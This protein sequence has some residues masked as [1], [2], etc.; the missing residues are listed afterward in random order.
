MNRFFAIVIMSAVLLPSLSYDPA[1]ADALGSPTGG[2]GHS[3][4]LS[5]VVVMPGEE[6]KRWFSAEVIAEAKETEKTGAKLIKIKGCTVCH[7]TDGTPLIGPTF[8]GIFK[9]KSIVV[10]GGRERE[11]LADEE[12]IR[13]SMLEPQ[14]DVVKGFPPIMP[15]QKGVVTTEEVAAIIEYLKTLK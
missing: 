9:R 11:V 15:S 12:Y 13:R 10:T 1:Y 8:K 3:K 5:S 6:F 7:T 2:L 4:M 14:A